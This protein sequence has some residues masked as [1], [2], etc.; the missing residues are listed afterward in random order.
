MFKTHCQS[1]KTSNCALEVEITGNQ[2]L[3]EFY[4]FAT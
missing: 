4:E 3:T 2:H 1:T